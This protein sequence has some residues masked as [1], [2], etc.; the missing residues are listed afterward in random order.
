[1]IR[2]DNV[3]KVYRSIRQL[4]LRHEAA[5]TFWRLLRRM[6]QASQPQPFFALRNV[7]FSVNRGDALGIVG[8][9]GAGKTTLLRLLS[10]ITQPTSGEITVVGKFATLIGISA[11]FNF[12]LTGR[13]N[14]YL[15]SAFF[16][17]SPDQVREI[18]AQIVAFAE[19][20]E[21]IDAPVKLYSS[22]M[23]ARLGFSIAIHLLP[24]IIFLDEVLAVG[25]ARFAEKCWERI[26]DLRNS[27]RTI[28]MINHSEASIRRLC[29]RAIW[30]DHGQVMLDSTTDEVLVAYA[31]AR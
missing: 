13:K 28:V 21:F 6:N 26:T 18:E 17:W 2:V 19:I 8:R 30:L 1:M 4:S 31:A 5:N 3:S 29:T 16:G 15:N 20:G 7:S 24:D 11:G 9:N 12:E 23:V 25:D 22:G 27:D 14:I 10:G